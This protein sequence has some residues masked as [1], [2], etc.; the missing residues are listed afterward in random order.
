MSKNY[1]QQ[2]WIAERYASNAGFVPQLGEPLI[3][4]LEPMAGERILDLGC[5]DGALTQK[6]LGFNVEV[7]G[8][9]SSTEQISA[10]RA[11]GLNAI[12][13]DGHYLGF[14]NEFDAIM[15][16]A[17][18]HWMSRDPDAVIRCMFNA[19]KPGGRLVA[20]MGGKGNIDRILTALRITLDKFG[21]DW[22]KYC[23]WYFPDPKE[24]SERLTRIGF[25]VTEIELFPRPTK[26]PGDVSNWL[27]TFAEPFL[28][29]VAET[30]RA[31]L[32]DAIKR[33]LRPF[34]FKGDSWIID[35]MR[36]RFIAKKPC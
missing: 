27:E 13:C 36:L 2:R 14:D 19:L 8:V 3:S 6:L 34:L 26:L 17:A 29:S 10:A 30:H 16:N 7:L 12:V 1:T 25:V 32:L 33:E 21:V 28:C 24:Y 4:L 5:G 18:L 20:E 15:S 22:R 11:K 23:S 31:E 9:D 35:Y